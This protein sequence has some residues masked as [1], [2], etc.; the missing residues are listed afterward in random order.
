M[1]LILLSAMVLIVDILMMLFAYHLGN[2]EKDI[3]N[4]KKNGSGEQQLKQ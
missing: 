3:S 2:V 1:N 4:E